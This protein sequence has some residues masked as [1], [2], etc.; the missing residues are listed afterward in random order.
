[1]DTATETSPRGATEFYTWD[2]HRCAYEVIRPENA[3]GIPIVSLHP[4][5]VGLTRQFW[6]R[7]NREWR[8]RGYRNPLYHPD[9]LGNGDSD[10][11]RLPYAPIDWAGQIASLIETKIGEPVILLSQGA[12]L[13]IAIELAKAH[14]DRIAAIVLSGPPAWGVMTQPANETQQNLSWKLFFNT[15]LGDWFYRYART[16]GFLASFSVK[17]LFDAADDVDEEWM[18]MLRAN[19]RDLDTRYAVLS[20]LAGFWRR[21]YTEDLESLAQPVCAIFG[22]GASSISQRGKTD[23]AEKR[24]KDYLAHIPRSQAQII[25]GRN[26]LP[27][28]STAEFVE[29]TATFLGRHALL[30]K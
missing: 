13:P 8:D 16:D 17:Q 3:S 12:S 22:E 21:D 28:E 29:A 26:V 14:P 19:S 4:I 10:R 1:M 6:D 5:G 9:L 18:A 27:Y 15:I 7:F 23:P 20:F 24:V 25:P 30:A 11:P 2:G